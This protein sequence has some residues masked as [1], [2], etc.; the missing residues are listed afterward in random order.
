VPEGHLNDNINFFGQK[1]GHDRR[2]KSK[3]AREQQGHASLL[4]VPIETKVPVGKLDK[5][6]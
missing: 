3:D 1:K 2:F 5:D 4:V 6:Q